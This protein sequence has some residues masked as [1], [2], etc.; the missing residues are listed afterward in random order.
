MCGCNK[1]A[2]QRSVRNTGRRFIRIKSGTH[3]IKIVKK[4][5]KNENP[6]LNKE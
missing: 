4:D 6:E 3:Q 2:P 1:N 5:E